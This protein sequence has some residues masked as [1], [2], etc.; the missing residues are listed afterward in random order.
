MNKIRIIVDWVPNN[1]G[2]APVDEDI[3][4]VAAGRTLDEVEKN[5]VEAL[6]FHVDGMRENGDVIPAA[7]DGEW[8][9]V[10][11][12][13]ARAELKAAEAFITRK[14]L[15]RET[16]L[17]EQQ[18]CHYASGLKEPRPATRKKITDGIASI[19]RHLAA[20]S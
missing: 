19:S 5:I 7:L 16:G 10:F 15:A 3:A 1:F 17:N 6:H 20:I 12:L 13:T 2:A 18:L 11:A 4:C 8:E 14:A 9:P